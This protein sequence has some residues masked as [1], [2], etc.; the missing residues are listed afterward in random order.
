MLKTLA[1][2][3]GCAAIS[4]L[5]AA[6][7]SA[8]T[9]SGHVTAFS[10]TS[11]SVVDKEIV[12]VGLGD[13]T[14]FTKLV[15]SK[16]WQENVASSF[17]ALRVGAFVVFHVPDGSGFVADWVQVGDAPVAYSPVT[18]A[19]G[20]TH[21]GLKHLA[22]AHARRANPAMSESKHPGSIMSAAHCERL[23]EEGRV[24]AGPAPKGEPYNNRL[25]KLGK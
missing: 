11:I 16:P 22:E 13:S 21:E 10:P 7:A 9:V 19:F 1:T 18:P 4:F 20:F 23:A 25:Q 24:N 5:S 12:T 14:V 8:T 2:V 17:G 3:A 15:T 6:N